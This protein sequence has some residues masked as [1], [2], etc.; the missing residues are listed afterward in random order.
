MQL[1]IEFFNTLLNY[2]H[3]SSDDE[4]RLYL[5]SVAFR[6]MGDIL[7]LTAANGYC[8][9]RSE[10]PIL[11]QDDFNI[12]DNAYY[13]IPKVPQALKTF[14]K[15]YKEFKMLH[16]TLVADNEISISTRCHTESAEGMG[17]DL[18]ARDYP[19]VDHLFMDLCVTKWNAVKKIAFDPEL[20]VKLKKAVYG[21]RKT[22]EGQNF[23]FHFCG[24][25]GTQISAKYDNIKH[26]MI[27]IPLRV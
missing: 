5:C 22:K 23:V 3:V 17:I 1:S 10:H 24:Q 11:A 4:T 13:V 27:C 26:H 7:E 9:I 16:L 18:I 21:T 2:F 8:A 19:R 25:D 14:L 6:K 15:T 12:K 20:L